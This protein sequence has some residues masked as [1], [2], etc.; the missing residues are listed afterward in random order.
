M[1]RFAHRR[2]AD[3]QDELEIDAITSDFVASGEQI[4]ALLLRIV[5]SPA[6]NQRVVP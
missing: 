4:R 3:P 1:Y 2:P 5:D 6:F